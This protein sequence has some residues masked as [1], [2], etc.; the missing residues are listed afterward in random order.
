MVGKRS[1]ESHCEASLDLGVRCVV[2]HRLT[3]ISSCHRDEEQRKDEDGSFPV[4]STLYSPPT[5]PRYYADLSLALSI[6]LGLC[7]FECVDIFVTAYSVAHQLMGGEGS[8]PVERMKAS[9]YKILLF[10]E[11]TYIMF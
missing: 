1:S 3:R 10:I 7:S 8:V 9:L 5:C 6:F 11:L 4:P 2:R